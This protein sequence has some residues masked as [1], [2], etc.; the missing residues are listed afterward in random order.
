MNINLDRQALVAGAPYKCR[1][2]AAED[3]QGTN[4]P[5]IK[6]NV[7]VLDSNGKPSEHLIYSNLS[8][9]PKARFKIIQL[10]DSIAAPRKGNMKTQDLRNKICYVTVGFRTFEGVTRPEV[11]AFVTEE[12]YEAAEKPILESAGEGGDMDLDPEF[13]ESVSDWDDENEDE[14]AP[15]RLPDDVTDGEEVPF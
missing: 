12:T 10:L 15:G 11:V 4:A 1:I 13:E 2:E 3:K 7:R 6:L 8:M 5:Y 14:E 9:A